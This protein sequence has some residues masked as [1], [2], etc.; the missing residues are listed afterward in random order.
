MCIGEFK[1]YTA[2]MKDAR[3]IIRMGKAYRTYTLPYEK[4]VCIV[5]EL[6]EGYDFD[7]CVEIIREALSGAGVK[8]WL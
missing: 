2:P 8:K 4:P 7:E 3:V 1:R 6:D 5:I